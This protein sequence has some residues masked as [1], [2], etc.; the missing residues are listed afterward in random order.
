MIG[1]ILAGSP[2]IAD[3]DTVVDQIN[4][5]VPASC[6]FSD[7]VISG[8]T[9]HTRTAQN[10]QYQ[11]EIGTTTFKTYCNDL[12]GYSVYAIGYS[13]DEY[14]NTLMKHNSDSNNDFNTGTATSGNTSEWA[15]KLIPVTGTYAP[16]IQSDTNGSFASYHIVPS[17]YTKVA[18]FPSQTDAPVSGTPGIGSAFKSTYAAWI[19]A[20]QPAGTY[21]GKVR[22]TLVHPANETP[23]QPQTATPG[24]INYFAN[25]SSSVGTMG[26]Q[27]ATDSTDT[28]LLA[29]N[30]SR[31]G[32]GFA[33]WSDVYDYATNANAHFYGPHETI[34]TPADVSTNGL[35]LYAV[36]VPS[37]G[38]LQDSTKVSQLCG[39][40]PT[41]LTTAP[42]DGTANL[43]SVSALTDQRDGQTYAIAKLADGGCWMIEN[44][45]LEAANTIGSA[46]E[47]LAQGYAT[48]T[49]YG[50]FT[51][52]ATAESA[53][54]STTNPPVANSLYGTD[55]ST[56]NTIQ[57][58]NSSY[59]YARIPR[60][61]NLN[62]Q[63]RA[64][65]P[66]SNTFAQDDTTGGMYSYG[67]Y[68][69]WP[70]AIAN[71]KQYTGPTDQTEGT[72]SETVYTSL[73]PT[74]WRLPYGRDTGSGA[75]AGGF[76]YLDIRLGGTGAQSSS[77]TTPTGTAMS[78]I[79]RSFPNNFLYSGDFYNSKSVGRGSITLYWSSTANDSTTSFRLQ[80]SSTNVSPGTS[81]YNRSLGSSVRCVA[82]VAI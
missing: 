43:S 20:T 46:N 21:T 59:Y 79:W 55:G 78:R 54:F 9:A 68:Y 11:S 36:W 61:N 66:T 26:C 44:L 62:T 28:V 73:C 47:A 53:N 5:T 32:Y 16:T 8:D 19:S 58:G 10:G 31:T 37:A 34:T 25:A 45:R 39:V 7:E 77:N 18:T 41:S 81:T 29:S 27:S 64:S 22:Y 12:G 23:A 75:A 13:N 76:S 38:S 51:G 56:T 67:N 35:S 3:N 52:L 1:L 49:T 72:T 82:F 6:S 70:A 4:I 69:T 42:I 14:G 24:C 74:G 80:M 17:T 2:V 50:N 65:N 48:S 60:Y 40:G 15:M 30:F 33:G 71:I 57:G 63:S